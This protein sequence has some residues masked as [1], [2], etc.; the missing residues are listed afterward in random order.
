M[1]R[2]HHL[3]WYR[4]RKDWSPD[5]R[6]R[7]DR[8]EDIGIRV[9][10]AIRPTSATLVDPLNGR[11]MGDPPLVDLTDSNRTLAK[12]LVELSSNTGH[13]LLEAGQLIL[14]I[15]QGIMEKIYFGVLLSNN[16]AKVAT[17]TEF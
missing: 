1:K 5:W 4:F 14:E 9:A 17:L 13:D 2:R 15:L 12:V 6:R 8:R 16:L 3:E 11:L 10:G 7:G